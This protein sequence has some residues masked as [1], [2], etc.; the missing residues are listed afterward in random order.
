MSVCYLSTFIS[1]SEAFK[2]DPR[3]FL[4][5]LTIGASCGHIAIPMLFEILIAKYFLSGA[6]ILLA[7]VVMQCLPFGLVMYL[8]SGKDHDP[9]QEKVS[10]PVVCDVL[11]LKDMVLCTVLINTLL[12]FMTGNIEALFI[13]DQLIGKNYSRN[14]GSVLMSFTGIA[15]V[16]GR[17]LASFTVLKCTRWPVINHLVYASVVVAVGHILVLELLNVYTFLV[18]AS[19]LRGTGFGMFN[20][21]T[22][23]VVFEA[24]GSEKYPAAMACANVSIGFGD[25]L[26]AILGGIV[27]DAMG[28]YR[29]VYYIS[30]GT[31]VYVATSSL[32]IAYRI[33][34]N[35]RRKS[36]ELTKEISSKLSY[37]TLK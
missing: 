35:E 20:G 19:L 37:D 3:F 25:F 1:V 22:P 24:A 12:M 4:T 34:Q 10:R 21:L 33:Y 17:I 14:K 7:G 15:A 2:D 23:A 5:S 16:L 32:L 28:N 27:R 9:K 30:T 13:V 26:S 31:A 8:L 6:F 18:L 29:M 11:V 36:S